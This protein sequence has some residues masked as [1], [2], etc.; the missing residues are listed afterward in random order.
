MEHNFLIQHRYAMSELVKQFIMSTSK[1]WESMYVH[2]KDD[3][4][5]Q[6]NK[7]ELSTY[8]NHVKA[9]RDYT[10][11]LPD[12][13]VLSTRSIKLHPTY[14]IGLDMLGLALIDLNFEQGKT[15]VFVH[16]SETMI[17][18]GIHV[19]DAVTRNILKVMSNPYCLTYLKLFVTS[20]EPVFTIKD[21]Y[22][23]YYEHIKFSLLEKKLKRLVLLSSKQIFMI[24]SFMK[25]MRELLIGELMLINSNR[26]EE[27]RKILYN[28]STGIFKKLWPELKVIVLLKDCYFNICTKRAKKFTSDIKLYSPV[29]FT[30]EVTIG[31]NIDPNKNTY[32]I[33][34]S[35]AYFEFLPINKVSKNFKSL[36][37]IRSLKIGSYYSIVIST[38]FYKRYVVGEIVKVVDY[39]NSVPEILP[40]CRESDLII[41]DNAV[42]TPDVIETELVKIFDIVDF[43][44]KNDNETLKLYVELGKHNY[45]YDGTNCYDVKEDVKKIN[46]DDI[47][48]KITMKVEIRIVKIDVFEKLRKT[49]FNEYTDPSLITM[50]RM[51]DSSQLKNDILFMYS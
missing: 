50:N 2:I 45:L 35:K 1:V 44:Y 46:V 19:S 37:S 14:E 29:Y 21:Y 16:T 41:H 15:A 9:I 33:N 18:N 23:A 13:F 30:P 22:S 10:I 31:Y 25:E 6:I 7:L 36:K 11:K 39:Y 48:N 8:I 27:C 34:P 51:I 42:V 24:V 32:L 38:G 28:R 20:P 49:K 47:G 5:K 4:V 26:A 17:R 43:C 3:G 12:W 40:I